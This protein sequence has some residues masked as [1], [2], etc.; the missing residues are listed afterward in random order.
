MTETTPDTFIL[1]SDAAR[2]LASEP[3]AGLI[4]NLTGEEPWDR[5][6]ALDCFDQSLQR[7]GQL[8]LRIGR[9][10]RL[11]RTDGPPLAQGVPPQGRFVA[12]FPDGP[13]K[14]ALGH[15]SPLRGLLPVGSG[16]LRS[17]VITF[18]DD[19]AKTQ[20]RAHLDFLEA[21]SGDTAVIVTA[22]GLRGYARALTDLRRT[23]EQAGAAAPHLPTLITRLFPAVQAYD[24]KPEVLFAADRSAFDAACDII[25]A[26]LPVARANEAGII[27]D[28]DTE[29]LH[30][31][32]IALRKIRSVLSLFKEVFGAAQTAELKLGFSRLMN[33]TG[34]LRDLD[35]FLL[36]RQTYHALLPAS[37]HRGLD[38]QFSLLEK[39]RRL[40][41]KKL[42][43]HFQSEAYLTAIADLSRPFGNRELL[44]PGPNA[45]LGAHAFACKLIWKR[46]RRVCEIAG[47]IGPQ[48]DDAE[49]HALRIECKKLRYL[50]EFFGRLFPKEEFR[51]ILKPLKE[52]Q[53]NLG[54]INDYAVQQV[55]LQLFLRR[56]HRLPD[57]LGLD[58]AQ[59]VG[60][61]TTILHQRQVEERARTVES[62]VQFNGPEIQQMFRI[63]FHRPKDMP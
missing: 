19:N 35:V 5:F 15:L 48:T 38:A 61:L 63:L 14:S 29:F 51:S 59:S 34:R 12:D 25:L 56:A 55:N 42:A 6:T 3:M 18:T 43:R 54:L 58:M 20:V 60:A 8:L 27:A 16:R 32:R 39:E 31:Y 53:D 57:D 40:E 11:F 2:T 45:D 1:S 22:K 10:V 37:L 46:Y 23:L 44:V 17:A 21:E 9:R 24:A 13:V 4:P 36:D 28:H 50:M 47:T 52:L 26:Y 49:V 62:F 33:A 7:S 30:D 41:Q